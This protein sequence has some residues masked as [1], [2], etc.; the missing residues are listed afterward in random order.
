[1]RR[2]SSHK[3]VAVRNIVDL[4]LTANLSFLKYDINLRFYPPRAAKLAAMNAATPTL[5]L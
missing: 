1:M 3:K 5:S 4:P 2:L